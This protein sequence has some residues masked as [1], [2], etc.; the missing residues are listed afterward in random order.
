MTSLLARLPTLAPGAPGERRG[1][2]AGWL[3]AATTLA[4]SVVGLLGLGLALVVVQTLDPDGGLPVGSSARLAGQLWLL[5][6]GG[7]LELPSGPLRLAPLLLTAGVAW[8]LS[9][10][11]GSVVALRELS[12]PGPLA[13]VLAVV[14]VLHTAATAALA[15]AVSTPGASVA[16]LRSVL[17]ALVLA[18]LAGGLGAVRESGAGAGLADRFPGPG[19]ALVRA[20]VA[21]TLALAACCTAVVSVALVDDV[22]GA[23]RLVSGLGGASAGA[24]GLV[25]LS[26]LLLPNAAAAV[27]GLAAGPGFLVGAGTFVSTGGVTLGS[28][29]ALPLMAALPD[30]QAVPLLAFL[31]QALPVVAG[32]VAGLVLGRRLGDAD[33]GALTAGLW[34]VV[35]GV[36][37]G[38][39]CGLWVLVAGG[40]LGDAG[41]A[42]VGAP[43]L[44]TGLSIAAQAGIAA[45]PAAAV[46]RWRSRR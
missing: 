3:A 24:A 42:E 20:A 39:L 15:L 31:A 18:V 10:A 35:A 14:V 7:E 8:G 40:R 46:S 1:P 43:A 13:R 9:R 38:V 2:A 26:V 12:G 32:L 21:G 5:A 37:V 16:L 30:T 27:M 33:G 25:G 17:G 36:G 44:A 41:L 23:G 45:A 11:A 6:Q 19:R 34:G 4:V 29:P 22:D 28:V